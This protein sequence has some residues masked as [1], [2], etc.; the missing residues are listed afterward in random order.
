MIPALVKSTSGE[1]RVKPQEGGTL[2]YER[3][4]GETPRNEETRSEEPG[5]ERPG[6]EDLCEMLPEKLPKQPR[7][8]N[9]QKTRRPQRSYI[10]GPCANYPTIS[11]LKS[12]NPFAARRKSGREND[13]G[14]SGVSGS[15][16]MQQVSRPSQGRE[17]RGTSRCRW[18]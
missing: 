1:E 7:A 6:Y 17:D 18:G 8:K 11:P 16:D 5:V 4:G 14:D 13:G 15:N 12:Q 9:E 2:G 3:P 10:R